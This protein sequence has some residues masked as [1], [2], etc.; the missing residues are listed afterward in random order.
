MK[1]L[2][3][4]SLSWIALLCASQSYAQNTLYIPPALTGTTFNLSAQSGTTTLFS[5]FNT[6]TYGINGTWMAPTLIINK[7]DSVTFNVTNNLPVST[8]IHWHGL[9]LPSKWDGGPHQIINTGSIWSPRFKVMNDAATFWYHP[10]GDKKTELHVSKG[11]AGMIIV[12]DA[13]EAALTLPRTYGV[14]DIPVI[15]QSKAFDVLKQIA[16]ATED[17]T[18]VFVNGTMQP[19]LNAPAQVIRLRLLNGSTSRSFKL[20]FTGNLA[21]SLIGNDAGLLDTSTTLTRIQIAP[22]ERYEILLNLTGKQSQTI[23]L[24]NFGTEL[25]NGIHGSAQVG[26]TGGMIPGY[27]DNKLNGADFNV[28]K[29][30]VTA[31]TSTPV[32]TI[33]TT[34]VPKSPFPISSVNKERTFLFL[35]EPPSTP[36]KMVE[37]P[38]LING[39]SFDMNIVNDTVKLG[40]T[41]IWKLVNGTEIAHPFHIH[42]VW[43]YVL[44]INGVP[45]PLYERGKKDVIL[46][47]PKDTVRFITKFEDFAD[48]IVPFMYHCHLLHHEDEGMMGSFIV[49]DSTTSVKNYQQDNMIVKVYPNPAA[50]SWLVEGGTDSKEI[51]VTLYDLMGKMLFTRLLSPVSGKFATSVNADLLPVGLYVLKINSEFSTQTLQLLKSNY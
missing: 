11:M 19:Y 3:T 32:T 22:G 44:D 18:T 14:D 20:G 27:V 12:K 38:F 10:H 17:D 39:N 51:K 45:P 25:T 41:E 42:D 23:Y 29:I 50:T 9:H 24:K 46:V 8:T 34:L 30:M 33:P 15:I 40:H 35:P 49:V 36:D 28:L 26:T 48:P 4:I 13:A 7:G 37:G 31:P 2:Y 16:I 5:G 1:L 21:F 43:F 47:M 6:P